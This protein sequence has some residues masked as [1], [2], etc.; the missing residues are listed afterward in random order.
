MPSS[1][2][3]VGATFS[4]GEGSGGNRHSLA[5]ILILFYLIG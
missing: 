1:S 4:P 3:T 2:V 5:S